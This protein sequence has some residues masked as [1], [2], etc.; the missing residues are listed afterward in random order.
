VTVTYL[1]LGFVLITIGVGALLLAAAF[2]TRHDGRTLLAFGAFVVLYGTGLLA[3]S[4]FLT[5]L[6]GISSAAPE[7]IAWLVNYW[8]PIPALIYT[9]QLRGAGWLRSVRRLW[10]AWIPLAIA[11]TAADSFLHRPGALGLA[12]L[13]C[14]ILM[15]LVIL[16]QIMRGSRANIAGRR[17]H[18]FGTAAFL[19]SIIVD[20]LAGLWWPHIGMKFEAL[21]VTAFIGSLGFVTGRQFFA[22]ERERAVVE[23]EMKTARGIQ[24]SLLPPSGLS[25]GGLQIAARYVPMRG[26][27]GD[28]YDF[29]VVDD[30]R[31]G[32][33]VA[34][35]TGHGVPAALIASMVKVAFTG[36]RASV[37]EPGELLTGM[38]KALCGNLTGQF[39]TAAYV[40][41]DTERGE[42]RYSVA[43]HPPPILWRSSTRQPV[44]LADSSGIFM[45]LDAGVSYQD[46]GLPLDPG[47]RV[48]LYTDGLTEAQNAAG[49]FFGEGRLREIFARGDRLP[50]EGF[51][52]ALLDDLQSWSGHDVNRRPFEDDLTIV[53]VDICGNPAMDTNVRLRDG[54]AC[55]ESR[56][57]GAVKL[58]QSATQGESEQA[59]AARS[60][61]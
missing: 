26:I 2:W 29:H 24:E 16:P 37:A 39:V 60:R 30:H 3:R 59:Q 19:L 10:Q 23:H 22:R 46:G 9:E 43:G 7:S 44:E 4:T 6:L 48:L 13:P 34:D 25:L 41:F 35:V 21:G 40:F 56:S 42:L 55:D 12:Y 31:V 32:V 5:P 36:Q 51:A 61:F 18:Q 53:V 58:R 57:T 49:A 47:D 1:A 45:G 17:I 38:N 33:L 20:N 52:A 54:S 8:A 27:A 11:L 15:L 28:L 14:V 50:A